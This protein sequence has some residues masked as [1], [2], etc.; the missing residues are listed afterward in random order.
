M[1]DSTE[2][3]DTAIAGFTVVRSGVATWL[4]TSHR[5]VRRMVAE[6]RIPY[7]KVGPY[8]ASTGWRWPGGS[9]KSGSARPIRFRDPDVRVSR[10]SQPRCQSGCGLGIVAALLL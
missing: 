7:V 9:T 6:R 8:I 5:H 4:G 3:V 1:M 2:V 10:R